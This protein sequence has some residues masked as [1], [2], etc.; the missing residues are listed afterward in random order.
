MKT[1]LVIDNDSSHNWYKIF[2][3]KTFSTPAGPQP[4]HVEQCGWQNIT[5]IK[6]STN[7]QEGCVIDITPSD[8][9]YLFFIFF[10]TFTHTTIR[11]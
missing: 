11:F 1:L 7:Q 3:G 6:A 4:I 10:D 8:G 5:I 2:S 9:S